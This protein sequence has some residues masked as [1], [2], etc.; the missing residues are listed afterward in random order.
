MAKQEVIDMRIRAL[1]MMLALAL[2]AL[3][4][5]GYT[6]QFKDSAGAARAYRSQMTITGVMSGAGLSLPLNATVDMTLLEK[7]LGV[8]D[9]VAA[10]SFGLQQGT[11]HLKVSGLP[12]EEEEQTIDQ[13]LP[14]F[15]FLFNRTPRGKVSNVK[16]QG[17][18]AS[19]FLGS[20]DALV[21]PMSSPDRGLEF[22][23]GEL[24][25]GDTWQGSQTALAGNA[26]TRVTALYTLAGTQVVNGKT[27]LK[28]NCDTTVSVP[29]TGMNADDD[30]EMAMNVILKGQSTTLFDEAAGEPFRTSFTMSGTL[31][32]TGAETMGIEVKTTLNIAGSMEKMAD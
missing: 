9:Q 23:A 25:I 32:M 15:T 17:E 6:L 28:I 18:I 24:K 30:T 26:E 8:K 3:S 31:N 27:Y 22:P 11:M 20:A 21:T 13:A 16:T 5:Q 12:G 7:V 19:L 14:V 2:A 10:V 1:V 29:D 4:A